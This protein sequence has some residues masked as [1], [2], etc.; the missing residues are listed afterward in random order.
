MIDISHSMILWRR[1]HHS[2]EKSGY[3]AELITTRLPQR[4]LRYFSFSEMMP[5]AIKDLPYLKVGPFHTN[6]V[7]GLQ[8]A[9]D[10]L[11]KT[12]YQN[13]FYDY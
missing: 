2:R 3:L 10:L 12:Q 8:L 11:R 1:S 13:K 7:A 9:M 4:H 6:T 5:I